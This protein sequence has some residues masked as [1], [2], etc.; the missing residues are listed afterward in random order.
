MIAG[1]AIGYLE[2]GIAVLLS[3]I[4]VVFAWGTFRPAE[5]SVDSPLPYI[6]LTLPLA[7][8]FWICGIALLKGWRYRWR[9][10]ALPVLALI[11]A[12]RSDLWVPYVV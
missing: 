2:L 8:A 4:C 5:G 11:A 1:R 6:Y 7:V 9:L 12:W 10:H 3:L